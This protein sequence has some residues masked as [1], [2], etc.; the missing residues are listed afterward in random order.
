M[1]FLEELNWR[2]LVQD[3]SN[4]DKIR[5]LLEGDSFYV[6][7]DPTAPSLQFGNLVPIVV[8]IHLSRAGL[9]PIILFGGA[10]GAIGDPSGKNEER[11]LLPRATIDANIERQKANTIEILDRQ[12]V[13][14]AFVNNLDWTKNVALLDFL[15]DVGKHFPVNYMIAKEVVKARLEGE[16]ISYAEFSYML[17]QANDFL[18][19][20]NTHNCRLQIGGS[21]QW[22]NLTAGLELI[23][24]KIKGDAFAFSWP[25]ITDSEG[26]KFGKSESGS[27]WL[28]PAMTSPYKFHQYFLNVA[29]TEVEKLLRMFTFLDKDQIRALVQEAA[30]APEKRIG[31]RTLADS[32]CTLVHGQQATDDAKRSADVL[33]GGSVKGLS[34]NQL[35]EIFSDV[36]SKNLPRQEVN[37]MSFLDLLVAANAVSSK[38]E[39]KRLIK[40]GGTY[41]NNERVSDINLQMSNT[42]VVNSNL[43]VLRTGKKSYYLVKLAE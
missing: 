16:G 24:R 7:F 18:H 22:G 35:E 4:P 33:F 38:G 13:K 30:A 39:A 3:V 21:D 15:R 37:N 5:N 17:L 12:N 34:E 36:P 1:N 20:Y 11:K 10:T 26:K 40:N 23:R 19:L 8:A 9:K 14:A 27:L 28:D 42:D 25:L 43:F 2:G 29:D 31:Q 6:G 41:L 32:V